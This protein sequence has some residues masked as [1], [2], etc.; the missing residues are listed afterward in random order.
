[1][2]AHVI[3]LQQYDA[4]EI[5]DVLLEVDGILRD[6]GFSTEDDL[7]LGIERALVLLDYVG[8]A[9][10]ENEEDATDE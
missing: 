9:L 10:D 7:R 4:D 3:T 5:V 8:D 6:A 1:M 2:G